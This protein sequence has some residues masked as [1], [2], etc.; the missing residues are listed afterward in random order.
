[1]QR[2]ILVGI[3]GLLKYGHIVSTALMEITVFVTVDRIDLKS[4]I[5]EIFSG[6]LTC[7]PDVFH[8]THA[9]ALTGQHQ[10]LLD[11]GIRNNLH[12]FF[13]LLLIQLFALDVIVA[14]ES[15]IDTIVFTVVGYVKRCEDIDGISEMFA[16]LDLRFSRHLLQVWLCSRRKQCLEIFDITGLMH[17]RTA[18]IRI[19]VFVVIVRFHGGQHLVHDV[20]IYTFHTF[21]IFHMICTGR[22]IVL[23][24]VF[25]LQRFFIQF[26]GINKKIIFCHVLTLFLVS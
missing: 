12:F 6:K 9:A 23:Q 21:H 20:R 4:H 26:I 18:H 3:V 10:D 7:F 17:Q 16:G 2:L 14:V 8:V 5:A 1:M 24:A 11:T 13:D 22:R 25:P 15:T 19:R